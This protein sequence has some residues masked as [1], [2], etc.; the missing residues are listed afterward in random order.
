M[1][2]LLPAL[3]S[4]LLWACSPSPQ[5]IQYGTDKCDF[6]RMTIVDPP[7]AAELVTDKGKVYKF[8][9]IECM[10]QYHQAAADKSFAMRLVNQ[11]PDGGTLQAAEGCT[12]L[13]SPNLPSPMGAGLSAFA[14]RDSAEEYQKEKGGQ[15]YSW[16]ALLV[17]FAEKR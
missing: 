1:K 5:P 2:K 10:L 12:Y 16:E 14:D 15:L 17:H 3:F 7:F 11:Y 9:A 4:V 8:D 13:I 6:C